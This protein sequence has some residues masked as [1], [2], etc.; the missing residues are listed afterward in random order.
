MRAGELARQAE[1]TVRALRYYEKVGLV[2]P[3]RLPNGYRDYDPVAVRQVREIR[4]L[5]GLGLSVE[6][7]RPFVE[8]LASGHGSG[9]ECP[10]SL[11]AYRDA[12][13]ALSARIVRLTRRRDA[14]A[15][16]LRAA[17][18]RSMPSGVRP[19]AAGH[20]LDGH[21]VR[22]DP[23]IPSDDGT[24]DR[25]VGVRL[26][27]V[28]LPATDGS[29]VGLAALGPGRTVLYVYP[30]T[31]RPG[32]DLPE[33][34]DTIPGAQGCTAEACG[35]R[36]HHAELIGA[37]AARVYGLSSQPGHYQREVVSR[38]RL[39]FTMLAD[40]EFAVRD[41]LRLPTFSAGGMTL[42]RRLT[43]IVRRDVIEHVFYPV[44][45]PAQHAGE[46]LGWLRTHPEGTR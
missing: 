26:P 45:P 44:Y 34:W 40:P 2:V 21:P 9:D 10:A 24:A 41:A 28:T 46:V 32:V 1:V 11:A 38:L 31:G 15:Q 19:F 43:M 6:E 12:I 30:L 39:P 7:T 14:L 20:G 25:L 5:T 3:V 4:E 13:D 16:H 36:D 29:T 27:G 33:G 42:Y 8:C 17:A 35:F 37:G 18:E 22:C 23:P